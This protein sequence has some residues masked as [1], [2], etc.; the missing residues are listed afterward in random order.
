MH[1]WD[2]CIMKT[3]KWAQLAGGTPPIVLK[4]NCVTHDEPI[5]C[6]PLARD[7]RLEAEEGPPAVNTR[8]ET[9]PRRQASKLAGRGNRRAKS[10]VSD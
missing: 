10:F 6:T 8:M 1:F 2:I 4:I 3:Q 9:F 5:R 7:L